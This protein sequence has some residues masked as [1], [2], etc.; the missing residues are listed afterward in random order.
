[1]SRKA[2]AFILVVVLAAAALFVEVPAGLGLSD[3]ELAASE[4][5]GRQLFL[6]GCAPCH[7]GE[8]GPPTRAELQQDYGQ[9]AI[10][11]ALESPPPGMPPFGGT[12]EE[13]R[14][15]LVFLT[16]GDR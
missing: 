6:A 13:R 10:R 2:L 5:R 15:L 9:R 4:R 12:E 11:R 14:D 8:D 7:G 3:D 1:M 16:A